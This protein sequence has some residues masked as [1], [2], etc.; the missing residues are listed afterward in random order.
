MIDLTPARIELGLTGD[1]SAAEFY[2]ATSRLISHYS[3]HANDC[4][5]FLD[6]ED[7]ELA[8]VGRSRATASVAM[9]PGGLWFVGHHF[10]NSTSGTGCAPSVWDR[11]GYATRKE[12]VEAVTAHAVAWFSRQI[13]NADS[14]QNK[15]EAAAV[16][17]ALTRGPEA[18]Q[19]SL[20]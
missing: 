14:E 15:R 17:Q 13:D 7:E 1:Y 18:Q 8:N 2:A 11:A 20:F 10:Q 12:A 5:V 16:I 4:G 3:A 19:L 9:A 6:I